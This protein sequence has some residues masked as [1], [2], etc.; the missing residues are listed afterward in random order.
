LTWDDVDL[1]GRTL[2]LY[3]RKKRDRSL[4]PRRVPMTSRVFEILWRRFAERPG[5]LTWVFFW[6]RCWSPEE[7]RYVERPYARRNRMMSRLCKRAGVR[8]FGFHALRHAGASILQRRN[9][10]VTT[11]QKILVHENLSTTEIYLQTIDGAERE[12]MEILER[13]SHNSHTDSHTAEKQ[14]ANSDVNEYV[15]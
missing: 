14:A 11:V 4:T 5:D 6:H 3:T 8:H 10:P 9:V 7:N 13:F 15:N 1:E 2:I 12:A